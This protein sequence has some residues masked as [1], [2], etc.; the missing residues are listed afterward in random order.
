[1]TEILDEQTTRA[2]VEALLLAAEEP[3]SPGR[4]EVPARQAPPPPPPP[5]FQPTSP[6]GPPPPKKSPGQQATPAEGPCQKEATN[7]TDKDR[8]TQGVPSPVVADQNPAL[9]AE[10]DSDPIRPERDDESHHR[11]SKKDKKQKQGKTEASKEDKASKDPKDPDGDS[12]DR[13]R[14]PAACFQQ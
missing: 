5:V 10:E 12:G 3:L 2:R 8:V 6:P 7:A 13:S 9:V 4:D 11:R 1:M 14:H